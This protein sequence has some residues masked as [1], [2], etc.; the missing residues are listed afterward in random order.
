MREKLRM[1]KKLLNVWKQKSPWPPSTF[2]HDTHSPTQEV[3]FF[4]LPSLPPPC[5]LSVYDFKCLCFSLFGSWHVGNQ[6]NIDRVMRDEKKA[7]EEEDK[8]AA[9]VLK[10]VRTTPP[11]PPPHLF[12]T[13]N[14][15]GSDRLMVESLSIGPR[16]QAEFAQVQVPAPLHSTRLH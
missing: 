1:L 7:A 9:K 6:D 2:G 8:K 16:S 15:V 14:G 10:A 4:L 3:P 11:H 5:L 13:K 12:F